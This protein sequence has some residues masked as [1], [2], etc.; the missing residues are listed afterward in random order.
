MEEG[1]TL[2]QV[3]GVVLSK[4]VLMK[5]RALRR[6]PLVK[7]AIDKFWGA[8][9][10][11]KVFGQYIPKDVYLTYHLKVAVNVGQGDDPSPNPNP[12]NP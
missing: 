4:K 9:D 2:A 3:Q 1:E 10:G 8:L 5:R 7:Q 12:N 11:L 6:H